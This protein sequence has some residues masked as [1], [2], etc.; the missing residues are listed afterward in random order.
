MIYG[1]STLLPV[2]EGYNPEIP[3]A[4]AELRLPG[5]PTQV[6]R[7]RVRPITTVAARYLLTSPTMI[8]W[9]RA[10]YRRETLEGGSS[11]TARI[12]VDNALF[13]DYTVQF[14]KAP[15]IVHNGYRGLLTCNY[16]ILS[17]NPATDCDYLVLYDQFG[18]C[19]N[20]SLETLS[21]AVR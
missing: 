21:D 7:E 14:T 20:C 16:E 9:Y 17:R 15:T 6:R 4:V 11:F 3:R 1:G 13:A 5:G 18:N 12:A 2:R 19:V 10:W 8:C